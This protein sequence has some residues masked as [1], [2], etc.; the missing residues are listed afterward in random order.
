MVQT[1]GACCRHNGGVTRRAADGTRSATTAAKQLGGDN[2][3]EGARSG[4]V[5]R[6]LLQP[7][8]DPWWKHRPPD[9][10]KG[11]RPN[12]ELAGRA[13]MERTPAASPNTRRSSSLPNSCHS[14]IPTTNNCFRGRAIH[15]WVLTAVDHGGAE[16]P[17]LCCFDELVLLLAHGA[18]PRGDVVCLGG[19]NTAL[20]GAVLSMF[21][22]FP[23]VAAAASTRAAPPYP[24]TPDAAD[25]LVRG[26]PPLCLD[27]GGSSATSNASGL[28]PPPEARLGPHSGWA[29]PSLVLPPLIGL[30]NQPLCSSFRVAVA[31]AATH[32]QEV[33]PLAAG[34]LNQVAG[35]HGAR[36]VVLEGAL[37]HGGLVLCVLQGMPPSPPT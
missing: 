25:E 36:D 14:T 3:T 6:V 21:G 34:G 16:V 26:S 31:Q 20:E 17:R 27:A 1:W 37:A 30:A 28:D 10:N 11:Q 23:T 24:P 15:H 12:S 8:K 4:V 7:P 22:V 29:R 13:A 5:V 9:A 33:A 35:F 2:S 32:A 18:R 19:R